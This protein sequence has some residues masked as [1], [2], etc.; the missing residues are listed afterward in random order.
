MIIKLK[1]RTFSLNTICINARSI[2]FMS[3]L[4]TLFLWMVFCLKFEND[5]TLTPE[6]MKIVPHQHSLCVAM[7]ERRHYIYYSAQQPI[8]GLGLP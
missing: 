6:Q 3:L 8:S 2:A 5:D 4:V 7:K 1:E